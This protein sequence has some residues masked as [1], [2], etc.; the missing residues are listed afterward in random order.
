M[1][2]VAGEQRVERRRLAG[3]LVQLLLDRDLLEPA[4]R[5]QPHVEDRLDLHLAEA[6]A[7]HH[8]GLRLVGLA[9][10]ADH[11]VEIDIDDDKA[12]QHLDATRDRGEAV[13]ALALQYLAA[14]VEK[15]LQRLLQIHHPRHPRGI[16][17]I[18]IERHPD[19]QLGQPEQLLHH[20]FGIDVA[21]LRLE[22]EAHLLGQF[23]VD[24]GEQRQFL[25]FEQC[26]DL[27]DQA[28]LGDLIRDLG[29]DDLVEPVGERLLLPAGA[30]AKAAAAGGVGLGDAVGAARRGRRRSGN[31]GRRHGRRARPRGRPDCSIRCSRAAHSS[32]TLCGGM[33]V[34]M[35]TAMPAAP[36]AKQVGK[37]RRQDDRLLVLAVIGRAEIDGILVEP[38]EHRLRDRRQPALGVAH[39]RGVIAV[40]IAEIA[41]PVDQ[42]V[43]LREIL[44]EADQRVVDRQLAVRMELADHVADDAGAF[45]VAGGGIEA[46]LMHRMEDAAMHRLQPI[47][48]IGQGARHDRRQRVGQI[49]LAERVGEIDVAGLAERRGIGHSYQTS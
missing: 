46:Q 48:H 37:P 20:H 9:D 4:Q 30:Q 49:A 45:L 7:R 24:V 3:Q 1:P 8:L 44:G 21:G 38:V 41:L 39:R 10:D 6:P 13:P 2:P 14:V 22:D 29:D 28:A 27:L 25:F 35:P 43:A 5:A 40:D 18:E 15:G 26:R 17:D 31:R 32:P 34:A 11:L 36:L 12:A 33:L 47:A 42:R 16:D 23:V 19:F